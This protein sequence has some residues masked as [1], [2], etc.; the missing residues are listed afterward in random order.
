MNE[1]ARNERLL[2]LLDAVERYYTYVSRCDDDER[3]IFRETA[4]WFRSRDRSDRLS[5]ERVCAHLAID[6]DRIRASLLA[7]YADIH[8]ALRDAMPR[9]SRAR[10]TARVRTER[11]PQG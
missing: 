7:G 3:R 8:G 4:S 2:T 9:R 11:D 10:S 5:F 6:P 1:P